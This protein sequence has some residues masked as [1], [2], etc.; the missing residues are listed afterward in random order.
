MNTL[1]HYLKLIITILTIGMTE[2]TII[3]QVCTTND[4]SGCVCPEGSQQC[5]LLPDIAISVD[6]LEDESHLYEQP[7]QLEISVSTPNIGYGPLRVEPSNLYVCGLDTFVHDLTT[8]F[9]CPDGSE[10]KN[11]IYQRVYRKEGDLMTS[12]MR[13]AGAMTYHPD[14][15]HMHVDDWGY[16]TIRKQ[17]PGLLPTDWPI[18][19]NGVKLGFCLMDYGSCG[20]Y[21]GYCRDEN[22]NILNSSSTIPNYGLGGGLYSCGKTNQGISVGWT[23]V[24]FNDIPGMEI[25]IPVG[26][27]NGNYKVV[28]E[29]DPLNHFLESNENNNIVVA[30]LILREQSEKQEEALDLQG[31]KILCDGETSTLSANYGN[32]FLWST[33]ATTQSIEVTEPGNYFCSIEVDCGTIESDT[34]IFTQDT[35]AAPLVADTISICEPQQLTLG[36]QS[37]YNGSLLWFSDSTANNL[38]ASSDTFQTPL[39]DT[40]TTFWV[41]EE[42]FIQGEQFNAGMPDNL[43]G[44]TAING[45]AYNGTLIFDVLT[46]FTLISVKTYADNSGDRTF[47]ILDKDDVVIHQKSIFINSG[48]DRAILNFPL[49]MGINYKIQCQSHPGFYRNKNNVQYPYEVTGII[50]IKDTNFGNTF[51]YYFYDWELRLT[52]RTCYSDIAKTFVEFGNGSDNVEITGLPNITENTVTYPLTG[53][54]AGGQFTGNGVQQNNFDPSGLATGLN[55]ITYTKESGTACESSINKK[56]LIYKKN[57]QFA[58]HNVN[59]I[60]P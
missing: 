46:P 36:A 49:D 33:G 52:D 18:V 26:T 20:Q 5:D 12:Y 10:P 8:S 22:N 30:D 40:T 24:Y 41:K 1:K 29:I 7:G 27:C 23:D 48:E 58:D 45:A 2:Q 44:N 38:I 31:S 25:D 57:S 3:A 42:V 21:N 50:S 19:G 60:S 35:I 17:V 32:N 56:L 28:V 13:N 39:I 4:A 54:P 9:I 51:Y 15:N 14:H 6:L 16:Y 47:Q 43:S 55:T 11:L 53:L 34:I 37:N 59:T